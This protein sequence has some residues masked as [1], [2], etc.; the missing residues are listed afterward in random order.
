MDFEV[1]VPVPRPTSLC[2]GG[3]DRSTMY[4]T[5][6]RTRLP[7]ATLSE[8]PLSGGIFAIDTGFRG[9]SDNLFNLGN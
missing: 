1:E 3:A 7:A 4:V 5:S 9:T 8:A 6:A 2:F